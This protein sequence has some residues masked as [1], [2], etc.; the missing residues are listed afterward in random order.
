MK[1]P[2]STV[3]E[4]ATF[5]KAT[6]IMKEGKAVATAC[7]AAG[8]SPSTYRRWEAYYGDI[9]AMVGKEEHEQVLRIIERAADEVRT[10]AEAVNNAEETKTHLLDHI[11]EVL[12]PSEKRD[13][14]TKVQ[15]EHG[16]RQTRL[17]KLFDQPLSTQRYQPIPKVTD[18]CLLDR[19]KDIAEEEPTLGYRDV[20]AILKKDGVKVGYERVRTLRASLELIGKSGRR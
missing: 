18:E 6:R 13:L 19:I 7:E 5:V 12:T 9:A 8:I 2:R 11:A 14:I 17:C 20:T 15:A 10:L 1:K 4:V 3:V 16:G